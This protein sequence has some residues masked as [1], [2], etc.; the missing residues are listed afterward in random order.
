MTA[1]SEGASRF[2][3]R[4]ANASKELFNGLAGDLRPATSDRFRFSRGLLETIYKYITLRPTI[5]TEELL[6][7]LPAAGEMQIDLHY[8]F[9]WW[10]ID[11]N[12]LAAL[13]ALALSTKA[14]QIFEFGTY[15]GVATRQLATSCP[16]ATIHSIDFPIDAAAHFT[17]GQAF[18]GTPEAERITQLY[19]DSSSFDF[20]PFYNQMDLVFVDAGHEYGDVSIDSA[21]A[22]KMVKSTGIVVWDDYTSWTGVRRCINELQKELPIVHL[23]GTRLAFL[24]R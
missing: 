16:T 22:L 17:P 1:R 15:T 18:H 10:N 7:V 12:S 20:A 3:E 8:E 23:A 6:S 24:A 21:N 14:E 13:T 2:I 11:A 4:G 9:S 5:P 19:G